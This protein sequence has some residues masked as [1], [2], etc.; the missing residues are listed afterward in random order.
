MSKTF[1]AF[2]I[3]HGTDLVFNEETAPNWLT[4][5]QTVKGST[6]DCRW[7]WTDHVLKLEVGDFIETDFHMITRVT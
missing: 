4:G 2:H 3:V 1:N 7:F 5:E 6:M